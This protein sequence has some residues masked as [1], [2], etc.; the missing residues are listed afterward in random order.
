MKKKVLIVDD[1]NLARRSLSDA[2]VD[3]GIA[4]T[5]ATNGI[6]ALEMADKVRP[7]L[8]VTDIIMP[9][10]DGLAFIEKLHSIDW[11]K[12]I[13][14]IV[15]TTDSSA[16]TLNGALIGGVSVYLSKTSMDLEGFTQQIKLALGE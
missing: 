12:E 11:A 15:M 13:P 16:A 10:M 8:I 9:E 14:V 5:Q 2:L 4:V 6:N 3:M 7:D 1:D